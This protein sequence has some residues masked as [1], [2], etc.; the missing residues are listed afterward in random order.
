MEVKFKNITKCT[1]SLYNQFLKFHNKKYKVRNIL[2]III[3]L[4]AIIYMVIFNIKYSNYTVA[5][6]AIIL[7]VTTF[8]INEKYQNNVVKEELES[9]KIEEQ[10]KIEFYFYNKYYFV[11]KMNKKRQLVRYFKIYRINS[12]EKN[13][14]LYTDKTHAFIVSKDGFIKGTAKEFD[15][16]MAKKCK[17]KYSKQID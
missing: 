9:K 8:L 17:F 2:T 12:D 1:E 15:E 6:F 14:Y 10:E 13:F 5:L 7:G 4:I 3:V 16:F 11:V